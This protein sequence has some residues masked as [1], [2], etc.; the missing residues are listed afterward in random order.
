VTGPARNF[1]T[2]GRDGETA[3]VELVNAKSMN[4]LGSAAIE[5]LTG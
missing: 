2:R 4:I 1:V 3:I 5:Q